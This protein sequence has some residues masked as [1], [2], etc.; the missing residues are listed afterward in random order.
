MGIKGLSKVIA[1]HAEDAVKEN[2][3]KAYFGRTVV[4]DASMSIYQFL[5]AVRAQGGEQLTND[6]GDV[7][8]HLQGLYGRTIRMLEN[9][10]K[11]IYVFDG[12]APDMKSGELQKRRERM[13]D[14]QKKA[15][16][17]K[18]AGD[19]EELNKF[20]R[21]QVRVTKQQNAECQELLKAMGLPFVLAPGEAEAQCA[22]MVKNGQAFA[23][24]TEDMDAL[25]FGSTIMLRHLTA[26]AAKKQP[27]VE[28]NLSKVL[29]G[30][31]H[32]MDWFIDMCV[33]L[34][35]DYTDTIRG[36]GPK[37]VLEMM[38]KHNSIEKVIEELD[39]KKYTV[40]EDKFLYKAARVLFKSPDVVDVPAADLKFKPPNEQELIDLLVTKNQ[41]SEQTVKNGVLRMQ[42]A[43]KK[44]SQKRVDDF[45]KIAPKTDEQKAKMLKRKGSA[46]AKAGSAKK[47]KLTTKGKGRK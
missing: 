25:T 23:T 38:M 9:G 5:I 36:V 44:D 47:T 10:I 15:E 8:S 33:L 42:K 26:S 19:E 41:F 31:G 7:T 18:E 39:P 13:A 37:K 29:D 24:A 11:P 28:I 14:A 40:D 4:I 45:F 12:K 21:R 30:L 2:D 34:G 17:A 20:N 32:D 1:E 22:H 35:C 16:E 6:N 27:I 43:S 46:K 3:I